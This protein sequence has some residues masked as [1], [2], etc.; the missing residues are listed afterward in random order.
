MKLLYFFSLIYVIFIG[1]SLTDPEI[2]MKAPV[3]VEQIEPK[4][5]NNIGTA[6][7][8]F[9]KGSNPLFS[10]NKAMNVNDIVT[11]IIREDT[12]QSTKASKSTNKSSNTNLGGGIFS[13][14]KAD[15]INKKTN[16]GFKAGS[17]QEFSGGGQASR[18]DKFETTI[19]ARII[20]VL[21]NGNYFI[22]GKKQLL[23]NGEKQI[24]QISG[25]IRPYDITGQNTI[26]SKYISDAKI[27]Y[28]TQG[29]LDK[30]TKKSWG[31]KTVETVWPF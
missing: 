13:G 14:E 20:K 5:D 2:D 29:E 11:I 10:D 23:I 6:G 9:G 3:Y 8:L 7:S 1:C 18:N 4:V 30:A 21:S 28:S 19:S 25:V 27:L 22:E 24:V 12:N 26:E 16:I 15:K 31:T 17:S